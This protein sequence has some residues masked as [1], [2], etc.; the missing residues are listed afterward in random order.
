M[1][2]SYDAS[3]RVIFLEQRIKQLLTS[4]NINQDTMATLIQKDTAHHLP[5]MQEGVLLVEV[6]Q[7]ALHVRVSTQKLPLEREEDVP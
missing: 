5:R 4:A 7:T 6:V 2:D 3:Q 1:L